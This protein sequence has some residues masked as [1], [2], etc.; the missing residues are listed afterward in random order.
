MFSKLSLLTCFVFCQDVVETLEV[1]RKAKA[2]VYFDHK[3]SLM[4][5][6]YRY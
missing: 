4:V 6:V 3:K 2:K 1:K 5:S